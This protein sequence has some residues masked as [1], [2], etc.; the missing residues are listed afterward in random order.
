MAAVAGRLLGLEVRRRVGTLAEEEF[1]HFVFEEQEIDSEVIEIRFMKTP[2]YPAP[3]EAFLFKVI[4]AAF[5]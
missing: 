5:G 4:K 1:F 2:A 3:D